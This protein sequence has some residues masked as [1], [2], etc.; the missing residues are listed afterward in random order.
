VFHAQKFYNFS[1]E[2]LNGNKLLFATKIF[3]AT[4]IGMSI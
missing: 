1:A 3:A 4:H 2:K